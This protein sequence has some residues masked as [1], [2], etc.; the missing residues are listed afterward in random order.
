MDVAFLF[1]AWNGEWGIGGPV[2]CEYG[3]KKKMPGAHLAWV[4]KN[5]CESH[6]GFRTSTRIYKKKKKKNR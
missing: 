2:P 6:A 4:S 3:K 5:A 1:H